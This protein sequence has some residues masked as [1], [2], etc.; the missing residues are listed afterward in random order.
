MSYLLPLIDVIAS[1]DRSSARYP[2]IVVLAPN[3]KL[4]RQVDKMAREV[5]SVFNKNLNG[6]SYVR[7]RAVTE[8][9]NFWQHSH[10]EDTP[11]LLIC[12]PKYLSNFIRGPTIFE[13]E[14]FQNI[15]HIVL[16]EA[17]MLLEGSYLHDVEQIFDALRLTRRQL[18]RNGDI[19][20]HEKWTRFILSAATIP[21]FGLKSIQAYVKKRFPEALILR[22]DY[23]H[24]H[25]PC[26]TQRFIKSDDG[27]ASPVHVTAIVDHLLKAENLLPSSD[28]Q[29]GQL[30]D[31]FNQ[32]DY[33]IMIFIT[34]ANAE[35]FSKT[36]SSFG[37]NCI[38]FHS[39]L[40]STEKEE[41]LRSFSSGVIPIMVCTDSASRGLD[42]PAVRVVVQAEFALNVVQHLHRIGRASRAGKS[43]KAFNFYSSNCSELVES[44][45]GVMG[46]EDNI[47]L[48]TT[49]GDS[50]EKSFSRKRGF[51]RN[52]KR[53]LSQE[54]L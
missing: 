43:G 49:N 21:S 26:I 11:S 5:I 45:I 53:N 35:K 47:I 28:F 4:V 25:L 17:D 8:L 46:Q 16:D 41:N 33:L 12:T 19:L 32:I 9:T 34:A 24:A 37:V 30:I 54:K 13:P 20:V 48:D 22:S 39:A 29:Q 2:Y 50:I 6:S 40:S 44:I 42:L 15:R 31:H 7:I 1:S 38:Q 18:V 14:L 10:G 23:L 51:R 27:V 36:L 3:K 52:L